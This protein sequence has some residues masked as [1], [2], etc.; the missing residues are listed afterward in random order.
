MKALILVDIQNDFQHSVDC[1]ALK[2]DERLRGKVKWY[3]KPVVFGGD[4]NPG[5]N[6]TW[7]SLEDHVQAVKY[8]NEMYSHVAGRR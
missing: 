4:P 7:I 3:V 5:E 6:M 8:W 2:P 1:A